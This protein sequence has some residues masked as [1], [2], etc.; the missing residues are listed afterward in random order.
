MCDSIEVLFKVDDCY[1]GPDNDPC[2]KQ[3]L[4]ILKDAPKAVSPLNGAMYKIWPEY[5]SDNKLTG[6]FVSINPP[7]CTIGNNIAPQNLVFRSAD[8]ALRFLQNYL[9]SWNLPSEMIGTFSLDRSELMS[10]SLTYLFDC[11]SHEAALRTHRDLF[12]R[13]EALKKPKKG[14]KYTPV[15]SVG[16]SEQ[17]TSYY[18]GNGYQ[19]KCYIKSGPTPKSY[20]SFSSNK[21]Q[22]AMYEVGSHLLRVEFD[23]KRTWLV[24]NDLGTPNSF[25]KSERVNPYSKCFNVIRRYFRM[26]DDFRTRRPKK[27]DL[28]RLPS[29]D[30]EIIELHLAG[31]DWR[32]H[33][34]FEG[35]SSSAQ[36]KFHRKIFDSLRLD[37]N[38][39]WQEQ[40]M[41]LSSS[42][43]DLMQFT[44]RYRLSKAV[45]AHSYIYRNV[46]DLL[47]RL[48]VL[49]MN[50]IYEDEDTDNLDLG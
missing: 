14:S 45:Q 15:R 35:K 49:V 5:G 6:V 18:D 24:D 10:V 17:F 25:K 28:D 32:N 39:P 4:D 40:R 13:G 23:A 26:D 1:I 9:L 22:E 20:E 38:I 37:L 42:L 19:I 33:Q 46:C 48:R 50:K 11:G 12:A 29:V 8:I 3:L 2:H 41:C 7:A 31:E 43:P 47:T 44:K 30:R 16:G 27:I 21:V 36:S 34:R